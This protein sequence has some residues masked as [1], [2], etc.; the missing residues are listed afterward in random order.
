MPAY[1]GVDQ[2]FA[3]LRRSG[4]SVGEAAFGG[5]GRLVWQAEGTN[6]ENQIRAEGASQAEAWH[7]ACRQAEALGM[8]R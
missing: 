8:L 1:P 2:S 7:N 5:G 3:R 6:G 4:W